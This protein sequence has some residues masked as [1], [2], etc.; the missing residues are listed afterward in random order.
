MTKDGD[1]ITIYQL[2]TSIQ[3]GGAEN[4]VFQLVE[5]CN[6][7][8]SK[9]FK[10]TVTE[11]HETSD[12]YSKEKKKSLSEKNINTV[13]LFKGP[14]RLSL[15]LGSLKLAYII[16]KNRPDI[17]HSHTDLPDF[18]L[19]SALRIIRLFDIKKP[20]I[21]RTIHSTELWT[22]HPRFAKYTESVYYNDVIASVSKGAYEAHKK[23]RFDNKLTL[24]PYQT[25]LY[26]GCKIPKKQ[27]HPFEIDK[28]KINIGFCGRFEKYKGIDTLIWII[29][30]LNRQYLDSFV[31]H[32]IGNGSY[33]NDILK[34]AKENKNVFVYDAV[35]NISDKLYEFDFIFMPSYFEGL[36]LVSIESSFAK[37]PVIA[38]FAPGLDETLPEDWPLQFNLND[39]NK[40]LTI[41][42]NIKNNTYDLNALKSKAFDFAS[43]NFSH[44]RMIDNYSKLYSD[45]YDKRQ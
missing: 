39:R 7:N 23:I 15:F 2:I 12:D 42:E 34:L 24:S 4:I 20:I 3:L 37:I 22:T 35:P 13:T 36:P 5:H 1:A 44:K 21:V 33:L 28:K 27:N 31:F 45:I 19:A 26:N 43:S 25:V 16:W 40:L 9:R 29:K 30:R 8:L 14:K 18:V 32:I 38:S 17:I 10:F 11:L 41:F 6:S